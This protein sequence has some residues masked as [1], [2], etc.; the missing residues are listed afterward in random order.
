VRYGASPSI[1][2]NL[3]AVG[4]DPS[5]DEHPRPLLVLAVQRCAESDVFLPILAKTPRPD[6]PDR[7]DEV[8]SACAMHHAASRVDPLASVRQLQRQGWTALHAAVASRSCVRYLK[9]LLKARASVDSLDSVSRS[10]A[11]HTAREP[12]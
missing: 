6:A 3:L 5:R 9:P 4:A 8:R 1:I 7:V 10:G 11:A 12:A 2:A